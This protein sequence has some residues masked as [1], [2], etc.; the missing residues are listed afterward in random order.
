LLAVI[1]GVRAEQVAIDKHLDVLD[2]RQLPG[3]HTV[4]Q[5]TFRNRPV[6]T[7]R[8]G[9]GEDRAKSVL[10]ELIH[11]NAISAIVSARMAGSVPP[12]FK[13]GNLAFCP[14]NLLWRGDGGFSNPTGECDIRLLEMAG[15]AATKAGIEHRVGECLTLPRAAL[16]LD[17]DQLSGRPNLVAADTN[18]YWI[19][20]TAFEH[21]IPLLAV[22]ASFG[23][24]FRRMPEI[25]EMVGRRSYVSNWEILKRNATQPHKIPRFLELA[26]TVRI[27]S[28][29]LHRFFGRF[30][31]EWDRNALPAPERMR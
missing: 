1:V 17:R 24:M 10:D 12:E 9:L 14:R 25:I 18:G 27:C 2:E 4:R 29:S 20:E 28:T 21:D 3:G 11:Q 19:A 22:R 31:E 6:L 30:L 7:C 16:P 5:G 26:R 15:H 8:T 13:V 23:D